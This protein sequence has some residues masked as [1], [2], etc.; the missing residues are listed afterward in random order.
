MSELGFGFGFEF[1]YNTLGQY[2]AQFYAPLVERVDVPDRALGKDTWLVECTELAERLRG[3]FLREDRVRRTIALEDPWGY[4]PVWRA[5]GLHLL[6]RFTE[7]ECFGLGKNVRE[8]HIVVPT[9]RIERLDECDKITRDQS[10]SL[11][12]QLVERVL[13]VRTW[14]A[15]IDWPSRV[16]SLGPTERNGFPVALHLQLLQV[17]REPL[18]VLLVRQYRNSFGT[19]EIVVPHR[20]K[21]QE[22]RQVALEGRAAKMLVHFMK[23]VE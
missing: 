21:A 8:Q 5:L 16:G 17:G 6:G 2:L 18:E 13:A 20:Q 3:Q 14:F 22:D 4:E 1:R 15:P 7:S 11:V 12:N 19:E 10:C 9:Q 23:T